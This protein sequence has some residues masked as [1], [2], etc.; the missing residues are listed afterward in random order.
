MSWY[1]NPFTSKFGY[2]ESEYTIVSHDSDTIL[3]LGDMKQTHVMDVSGGERAFW[4]PEGT[5]DDIGQ[6]VMLVRNGVGNLL[7]V[8]AFPGDEVLNST[9]VE[10]TENRNFCSL[11]LILVAAGHWTTPEFG[12][13][14]RY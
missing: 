12:I 2:T 8:W 6:W 3:T 13:W 1:F 14:T 7:R 9:Y 5:I 10:C 4:L 11:V